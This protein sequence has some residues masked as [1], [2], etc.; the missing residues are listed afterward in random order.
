MFAVIRENVSDRPENFIMS[1]HEH[2]GT[3]AYQTS[4][5]DDLTALKATVVV[6]WREPTDED[7]VDGDV[8]LIGE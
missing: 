5:G 8:L 2:D 3:P 1:L 6:D 7:E 4:Y